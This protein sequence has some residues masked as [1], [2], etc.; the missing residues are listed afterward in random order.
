MSQT[1]ILLESGTNEVEVAEFTLGGQ[2]FGVN[3]AKVREFIPL[4]GVDVCHPPLVHPSVNG[5]FFLRGKNI[6]LISLDK[7]LGLN[8]PDEDS[9]QVIVVTEF[10]NLT[11][12][13]ITDQ[14]NM[15]HRN[16]QPQILFHVA[17]KG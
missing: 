10:N 4:K 2:R 11:T 5:V 1:D 16:V 8:P 12:A 6:P 3:V 15:I 14:I 9:W 17:A 7:H 13:F